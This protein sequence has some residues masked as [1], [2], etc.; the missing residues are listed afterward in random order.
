M[1]ILTGLVLAGLLGKIKDGRRTLLPMF[2]TGPVRTVHW[3]PGRVRFRVPSLVNDGRGAAVIQQK[4]PTIQGV[5]SVQLD[6]NTGSV[7]V[8]YREEDVRPELLFAAIVRLLG[9]DEE[10]RRTPEP[11]VT[12]EL[13]E[14]LG[15]AN[16]MVYDRTGGL[17]DLWSA[18]LILLAAIGIGKL[19]VNGLR[20]FPAGLTLIWW[21]MTALLI[22]RQ[23]SLCVRVPDDFLA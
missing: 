17:I 11:V 22:G 10:V 2:R 8:V 19:W 18:T 14:I 21:G 5:R 7:L 23:P 4:L 1:H 3:L 15:S 12:K 20:A 16:R 13:R 6:S 9:L